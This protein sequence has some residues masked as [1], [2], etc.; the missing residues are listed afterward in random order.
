MKSRSKTTK[1]KKKN[2]TNWKSCKVPLGTLKKKKKKKKG[3]AT[4]EEPNFT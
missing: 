3:K 1:K 4:L 2:P